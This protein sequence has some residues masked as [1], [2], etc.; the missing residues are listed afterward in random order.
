MKNKILKVV[1]VV[2]AVLAILT[3]LAASV[4]AAQNP[5]EMGD[6]AR[7]ILTAVAVIFEIVAVIA[8]KRGWE[9]K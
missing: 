8:G 9:I 4:A 1:S 5:F 7:Y 3:M 6:A 2:M